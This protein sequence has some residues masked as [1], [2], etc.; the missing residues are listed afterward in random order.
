MN[1]V[2][3]RVIIAECLCIVRRGIERSTKMVPQYQIQKKSLK[4]WLPLS[5]IL[6]VQVA[7]SSE[8]N[9]AIT[10]PQQRFR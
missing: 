2:L 4:L 8:F 7:V 1:V 3:S 5:R 9:L 6:R 10:R